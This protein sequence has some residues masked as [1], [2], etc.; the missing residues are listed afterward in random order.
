LEIGSNISELQDFIQV[1]G[2]RYLGLIDNIN[3]YQSWRVPQPQA[4]YPQDYIIDQNGYVRY[5]S[6]EYDPKEIRKVIDRLLATGIQEPS[7]PININR[8]SFTITPNPVTSLIRINVEQGVSFASCLLRMYNSTGRLVDIL[9]LNQNNS[10]LL[11]KQIPGGVYF[12]QLEFNGQ[13]INKS[14]V[15]NK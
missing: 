6:D 14:F 10:V 3:L 8:L 12:V 9:K 13:V 1:F 2:Q 7:R 4:P 5:W 15:I 11:N